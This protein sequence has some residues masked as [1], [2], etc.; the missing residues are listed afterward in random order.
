LAD[1]EQQT[2][3]LAGCELQS[4]YVDAGTGNDKKV[5][6]INRYVT[7]YFTNFPAQL[8]RFYFRKGFKVCG[9]LEDVYVP[10]KRNALGAPYDF[11][12]FSNVRDVS[13]L[14]KALNAVYFGHFRVNAKVAS[15]NRSEEKDGRRGRRKL[16]GGNEG[17]ARPERKPKPHNS[18]EGS[19]RKGGV[20]GNEKAGL[21]AK[22]RNATV[23]NTL[24]KG[25]DPEKEV[26]VGEVVIRLGERKKK[27]DRT[28]GPVEDDNQNLGVKVLRSVEKEVSGTS[29]YIRKYSTTVDDV[30]WA[31]NGM[32]AS[33]KSGEAVPVIQRRIVDAGFNPLVFTPLG[34]DT[35]F[36]RSLTENDVVSVIDST[37]EFFSLFLSHWERWEKGVSPSKRGAWVRLYG[38]RHAWNELS[39]K[40]CTFDCGSFLRADRDTIEKERLDYDRIMIATSSLEVIKRKE[41]LI[42]DGVMV[43]VQIMEEWGYALGEDACLFDEEREEVASHSDNAVE[44]GQMEA[45][46]QVDMFVEKFAKGMEEDEC[47]AFQKFAQEHTHNQSTFSVNKEDLDREGVSNQKSPSFEEDRPQGAAVICPNF[48]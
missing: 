17:E 18:A 28:G 15:F 44:H 2:H 12:R 45:S 11:I 13:K 40:L 16:G 9:M 48:S 20:D 22:E 36:I 3:F 27:V 46:H 35:V 21:I 10:R 4:L 8:S 41:S 30:K 47:M 39:F 37:K 23:M 42:V 24:Q 32:V 14:S 31:Q 38:I 25:A 33:V 43:E 26:R 29:V 19:E 7:F 5:A 1:D 34:A 6:N